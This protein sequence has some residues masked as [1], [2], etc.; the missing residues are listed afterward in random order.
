LV[1]VRQSSNKDQTNIK[2]I[3]IQDVL[4]FYE[5]YNII[6]KFCKSIIIIFV[7]RYFKIKFFARITKNKYFMRQ[8]IIY[9]INSYKYFN[10]KEISLSNYTRFK[11]FLFKKDKSQ[12]ISCITAL[13]EIIFSP[14]Y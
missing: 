9:F 8:L 14:N 4:N 10:Y 13:L 12:F 11:K 7:H 1:I 6:I 2:N 5:I 3:Y